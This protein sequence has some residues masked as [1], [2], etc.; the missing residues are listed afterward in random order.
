MINNVKYASENIDEMQYYWTPCLLVKTTNSFFIHSKTGSAIKLLSTRGS[1]LL[2]VDTNTF[3]IS[4]VHHFRILIFLISRVITQV[5]Y[6]L[7]MHRNC[8]SSTFV[9]SSNI[10]DNE[11]CVLMYFFSL[12]FLFIQGVNSC[13]IKIEVT[14]FVTFDKDTLW[15]FKMK[16]TSF[17]WIRILKRNTDFLI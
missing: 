12:I 2:N 15:V 6:V 7:S 8:F 14:C 10:I 11:V 3:S 9:G 4:L 13:E 5:H 1:L 16:L 17:L